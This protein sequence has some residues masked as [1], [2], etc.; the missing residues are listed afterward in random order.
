MENT[1]II[2]TTEEEDKE[3]ERL[4]RVIHESIGNYAVEFENLLLVLKYGIKLIAKGDG[5]QNEDFI[6]IL[7]YDS[8]AFPLL[9]YFKAFML[10]AFPSEM[11][12]KEFSG[13]MDSIY[14][15]IQEAL[16]Y[17]N[18]IVHASWNVGYVINVNTDKLSTYLS[19]QRNKVKKDGL[20]NIHE[21][22]NFEKIEEIKKRAGEIKRLKNNLLEIMLNIRFKRPLKTDLTYK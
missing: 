5:L 15:E 17:R 22:V 4:T 7:L 21:R 6:E 8:T 11:K 1:G 3:H 9:N 12:D 10:E 20:T 13:K 16:E 19:A 18:D 2:T 14:G